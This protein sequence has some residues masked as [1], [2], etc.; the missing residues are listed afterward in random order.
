MAD[1]MV[2][3]L[4]LIW[5]FAALKLWPHVGSSKW[6]WPLAAFDATT[7]SSRSACRANFFTFARAAAS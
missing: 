5:P 2:N 6:Q 7:R 4:L 3:E 1:I